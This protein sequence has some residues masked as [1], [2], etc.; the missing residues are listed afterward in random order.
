MAPEGFGNQIPSGDA[1]R[2][3]SP[4]EAAYRIGA[5]LILV[6]RIFAGPNSYRGQAFDDAAALLARPL[7]LRWPNLAKWKAPQR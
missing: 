1:P 2:V 5:W 6:L 3:E 4:G 7:L